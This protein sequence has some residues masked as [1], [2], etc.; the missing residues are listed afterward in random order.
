[1]QA[2]AALRIHV[3]GCRPRCLQLPCPKSRATATLR[4][5]MTDSHGLLLFDEFS[6]SFHLHFHKLLKWVGPMLRQHVRHVSSRLV[7]GGSSVS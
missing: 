2:T 4:V 5:E 6:L 7:L 3:H 1:M